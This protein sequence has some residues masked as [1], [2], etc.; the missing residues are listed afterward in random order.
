[1]TGKI[2]DEAVNPKRY[3]PHGLHLVV[4]RR[5]QPGKPLHGPVAAIEHEIVVVDDDQRDLLLPLHH[6]GARRLVDV[7]E[8]LVEVF[9]LLASVHRPLLQF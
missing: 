5:L 8:T 9:E 1:M 3:V 7:H 6:V 4:E 2:V